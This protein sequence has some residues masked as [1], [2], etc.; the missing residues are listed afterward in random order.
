VRSCFVSRLKYVHDSSKFTMC[1]KPMKMRTL[2]ET[3]AHFQVENFLMVCVLHP[4]HLRSRQ[5]LPQRVEHST[6]ALNLSF[7]ALKSLVRRT[8]IVA[9]KRLTCGKYARGWNGLFSRSKPATGYSTMPE[10]VFV[11]Y[12]FGKVRSRWQVKLRTS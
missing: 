6:L 9:G 3:P 7:W 10:F 1:G 11:H 12:Y 4:V 2:Y 8:S 5:K